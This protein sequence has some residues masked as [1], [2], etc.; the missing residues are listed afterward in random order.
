MKNREKSLEMGESE[1]EACVLQSNIELAPYRS[2]SPKIPK[3]QKIFLGPLVRGAQKVLSGH[4]D[5]FCLGRGKERGGVRAGGRGGSVFIENTGRGVFKEEA[6]AG[7]VHR[8][9][10]DVCEDGGG[11]I[12]SGIP[13]K[14]LK[15]SKRLKIEEG[16]V[17]V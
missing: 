10:E 13:A 17:F 3:N 9:H 8:R 11:F 12:F 7:G 1:C 14:S 5:I 15:I 4:F 6:R 16:Q 2:N